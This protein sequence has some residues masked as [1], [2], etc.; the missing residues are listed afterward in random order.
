MSSTAGLKAE[1]LRF[2]GP[3]Q[4]VGELLK[5]R[6]ASNPD[7]GASALYHKDQRLWPRAVLCRLWKHKRGTVHVGHTREQE[8]DSAEHGNLP[9]LASW[10]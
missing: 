4:A 1:D 6:E 3:L 10:V 7:T 8:K 5:S 9:K 2:T